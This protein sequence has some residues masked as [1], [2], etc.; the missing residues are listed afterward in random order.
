[1]NIYDSNIIDDH[2]D[3]DVSMIDELESGVTVGFVAFDHAAAHNTRAYDNDDIVGDN[4]DEHDDYVEDDFEDDVSME[5][6]LEHAEDPAI[7]QIMALHKAAEHN[8]AIKTFKIP[9]EVILLA[10]L[11]SIYFHPEEA[12]V[13]QVPPHFQLAAYFTLY[14]DIA[15]ANF[16]ADKSLSMEINKAIWFYGLDKAHP[17][18]RFFDQIRCN[19]ILM[20]FVWASNFD[21]RYSKGGCKEFVKAFLRVSD[22]PDST[23]C[24]LLVSLHSFYR[25]LSILKISWQPHDLYRK[26][27]KHR[28]GSSH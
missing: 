21:P 12:V 8:L 6:R 3:D 26:L 28:P 11:H 22:S 7:M 24:V 2:F 15:K 16:L 9:K 10:S 5:D 25:G 20:A 18:S 14:N 13:P 17:F 1:V 23:A 27:I 19:I 4:Y